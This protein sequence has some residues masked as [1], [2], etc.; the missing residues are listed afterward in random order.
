MGRY[1]ALRQSAFGRRDIA[2]V[3]VHQVGAWLFEGKIES[4]G[5]LAYIPVPLEVTRPFRDYLG[6]FRGQALDRAKRALSP[7]S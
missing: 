1:L 2:K 7:E 6:R 4:R 3:N 5:T